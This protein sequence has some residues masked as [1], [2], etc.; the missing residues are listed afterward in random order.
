MPIENEMNCM[1]AKDLKSIAKN[2]FNDKANNFNEA[3]KK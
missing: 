1:S 3:I 2:Q